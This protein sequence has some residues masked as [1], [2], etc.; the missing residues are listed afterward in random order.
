MLPSAGLD[1]RNAL[2]PESPDD[3]HPVANAQAPVVA[4]DES[5]A[6]SPEFPGQGLEELEFHGREEMPP[7][8]QFDEAA[9][10]GDPEDLPDDRGGE[11]VLLLDG[12]T[13]GVPVEIDQAVGVGRLPS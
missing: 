11:N 10:G 8:G 3:F 13:E 4:A 1:N 5:V 9:G 7:G 12:K 6:P 2:F